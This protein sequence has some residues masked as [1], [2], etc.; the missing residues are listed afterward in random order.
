MKI[1]K[2]S[3]T[4][5]TPLADGKGVLLNLDTLCYYSLNRTGAALWQQI[6][7]KKVVMFDD[8]IDSTCRRFEVEKE[9]AGKEVEAFLERLETFKMIRTG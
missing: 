8:L 6:E 7:E 9:N 4:V 1:E 3:S 2:S 5:F